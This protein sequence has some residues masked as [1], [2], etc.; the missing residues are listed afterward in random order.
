MVLNKL[1]MLGLTSVIVLGL[2]GVFCEPVWASYTKADK[3]IERVGVEDD[4]IFSGGSLV[5]SDRSAGSSSPVANIRP[6][7]GATNPII[8]K[9]SDF[10]TNYEKRTT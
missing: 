6:V 5:V 2:F 8:V 7:A 1:K 3:A 9:R 10:G 4:I